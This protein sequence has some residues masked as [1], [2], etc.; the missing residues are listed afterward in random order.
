MLI[1]SADDKSKHLDFLEELQF[2]P[3]LEKWHK[4]KLSKELKNLKT[5][6]K[7]ET[8]AAYYINAHY[9]D[10]PN[11]AVLHDLRIVVDDEV[12]QIDHLLLGRVCVYLLETKNFKGDIAIN[13]YGEFSVSYANGNKYE[14]PSP[15]EQSRRHEKVLLKLLRRLNIPSANGKPLEVRH[16]ILV[17]PDSSIQRP[18]S[19]QF[20]TSNIIRADSLRSWHDRFQERDIG[21]LKATLYLPQIL[22]RSSD[23]VREWARQ[24]ARQ[25]QP[26]SLLDCLPGYIPKPSALQSSCSVELSVP[27]ALTR[28]DHVAAQQPICATCE[29]VI[30]T[31][32]AN[33]CRGRKLQFAGKLYC[34]EHQ[35]AFAGSAHSSVQADGVVPQKLQPAS[36]KRHLICATCGCLL[37]DQVVRYCRSHNQRF[38]GAL[39]CRQHQKAF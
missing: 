21:L 29:G 25:H 18:D 30:S 19:R 32:E 4:E 26:M 14:I 22:S 35:D 10:D 33:Y 20:D 31:A 28:P 7:G 3:V 16:V 2:S 6:L 38:G 27:E 36:T 17:H 5:G 8:E 23:N 12:A 9:A 1:K 15:L 39:Y 24:L 13:E 11:F 34:Y 37:E